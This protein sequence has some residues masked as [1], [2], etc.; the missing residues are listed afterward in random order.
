M[1]KNTNAKKSD[2]GS[3]KKDYG[4]KN[5]MVKGI[6]TK[7]GV[8]GI[9]LLDPKDAKSWVLW[10]EE[11]CSY[12]KANHHLMGNVFKEG[13][14]KRLFISS[15]Y[16]DIIDE[17]GNAIQTTAVQ[18]RTIE[19]ERL[20]FFLKDQH[21]MEV[22]KIKVMGVILQTISAES[23]HM[24]EAHEDYKNTDDDPLQAYNILE[25]THKHKLAYVSKSLKPSV[26]KQELYKCRQ[27][28]TETLVDFKDRFQDLC[29]QYHAT[30]NEERKIPE[31]ELA[32]DFILKLDKRYQVFQQEVKRWADADEI[33]KIPK[34]INDAVSK[35]NLIINENS[36]FR[37]AQQKSNY[38]TIFSTKIQKE[39]IDKKNPLKGKEINRKIKGNCFRCGK[40]GHMK[41][42]CTEDPKN[43]RDKKKEVKASSAKIDEDEEDDDI[44]V[45]GITEEEEFDV[46]IS[47]YEAK[48]IE[49]SRAIILDSGANKNLIGNKELLSNMRKGKTY[50]VK[51]A[52]GIIKSDTVGDLP[53]FGMA[54]YLDNAP[55]LIALGEAERAFKVKYK[56]GYYFK[57]NKNGRTLITFNKDKQTDMYV[58]YD[59]CTTNTLANVF[60]DTVNKRMDL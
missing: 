38:P 23:K 47:A 52:S 10:S 30:I 11:L 18:R 45:T 49:K 58:S 39:K 51:T 5:A 27:F 15:K 48:K 56:Q 19:K 33:D 26:I 20:T 55:N 42:D 29:D 24:L 3:E 1:S 31:E 46:D 13:A 4:Q 50:K 17:E 43:G 32:M 8:E 41:D 9:R 2:Q 53:S 14:Y 22:Q 57:C 44:Y 59:M 60:V 36:V 40:P 21:E 7:S 34:S 16:D 54:I 6:K 25:S 35:A 37:N 12:V 28:N